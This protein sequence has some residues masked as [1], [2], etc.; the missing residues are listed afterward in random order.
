MLDPEYTP[1][2]W[3]RSGSRWRTVRRQCFE[4]DMAANAPCWICGGA[5]DYAAPAHDPRSWE[6]D[7]VETVHDRPD[8]ALE[9]GNIRPAHAYCNNVRATEDR[10]RTA[11]RNR[12]IADLGEPSED[13]GL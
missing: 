10:K 2:S 12:H 4:R 8:L 6:P 11:A 9:P 3:G 1:K 13:F 5:I 7:H